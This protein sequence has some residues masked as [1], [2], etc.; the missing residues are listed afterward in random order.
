M[1]L[2][3]D[4][5]STGEKIGTFLINLASGAKKLQTIYNA[6]S[7]PTLAAIAAVFYDVSKAV[8]AGTAA[9]GSAETGNIATTITLSDTTLAL[10][11]Q[12]VTD[13]KN[14]VTTVVK[15]FEALNIKL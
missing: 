7:G 2:W 14:G 6:I 8:A 4:I 12:A 15:D 11:V 5:E 13:A 3:T 9:A 1:S 10:V